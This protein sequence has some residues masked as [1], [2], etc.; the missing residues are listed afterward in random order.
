MISRRTAMLL[1]LALAGIAAGT[2]MAGFAGGS[3][4]LA[5]TPG[6][7]RDSITTPGLDRVSNDGTAVSVSSS[8]DTRALTRLGHPGATTR[9]MAA[10]DE[11]ATYRIGPDCFGVGSVSRSGDR[12]GAVRCTDD[13]PSAGRPV[14]AFITVHGR[15][16]D[17]FKVVEERVWRSEGVAADGVSSVAFRTIDGATVGE[18]P[19]S[20]NVYRHSTIPDGELVELVAFDPSGNV[21]YS[22]PL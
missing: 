9:L 4:T 18:V 14:L 3:T 15:V 20:N 8:R 17:N 12:F 22:E 16:D 21:V 7:A 13:F 10:T 1:A 11:R 19:V 5:L 2:L 6:P